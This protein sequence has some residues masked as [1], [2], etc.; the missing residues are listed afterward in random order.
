MT[1]NPAEYSVPI[2]YHP[3]YLLRQYI[4]RVLR[5]NGALAAKGPNAYGG[6]DPF[7]PLSEEPELTQ[8][9]APYIVYGY[10]LGGTNGALPESKRG[11]MSM[12]I[13]SQD[14]GEITKIINILVAA[15][16]RLDQ[17]AEDVNYFTSQIPKF[18][19]IRF[20]HVGV[21]FVEGGTPEES[22]GGRQ[23][24]IVNIDFT[25]YDRNTQIITKVSPTT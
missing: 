20:G 13:Y 6:L 5:A 23:S 8:Y 11:S 9:S 4:L 3:V 2:N 16:G 19:G 22:E 17:S 15:L 7:V 12:V 24:G 14:F 10:V 18:I 21:N 1:T 25:Y